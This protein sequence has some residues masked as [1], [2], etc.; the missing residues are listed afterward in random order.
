MGNTLIADTL[1]EAMKVAYYE[2]SHYRVITRI[3]E[4]IDMSGA[5]TKLPIMGRNLDSEDRN[6]LETRLKVLQNK[7]DEDSRKVMIAKKEK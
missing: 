1:D 5:M 3:G 2:S 7:I 4:F 6:L